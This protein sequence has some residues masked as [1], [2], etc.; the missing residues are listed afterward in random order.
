MTSVRG[1]PTDETQSSIPEEA[2]SVS[3]IN[4]EIETVLTEAAEQFPSYIVGEIADVSH[5]D[6]GT[7][8]DL[9]DID[10]E[11][12]ISCFAWS[13]AVNSF[14]YDLEAG[15]TA[16]VQASVD[17]YQKQGDTRLVV[18]EYWPVGESQRV[19]ELEALRE[20]LAEEGAFDEQ[21][22]QPLPAYPHEVGVVTSPSGSALEDF[23]STVTARWPIVSICLCGASVQGETAIADLVEAIQELEHDPTVEVIVVT[24]GGG[25][26]A[27]L[28]VF[29]R[30]PVVRAIVEC[31]TPVVVAVGHEDDETLAERVADERAMTPTA[32]GVAVTPE[33]EA[34]ANRF[35][36]L[37]RRIADGYTGLVE[38]RL[39]AVAGRITAGVSTIEQE[40]VTREATQQ[41]VADL[42]RRLTTAYTSLAKTRLTEI[43]RRID[44][45]MQ[46]IEQTA[47]TEQASATAARGRM[48]DLEARIDQT[49][50]QTVDRQLQTI[51]QRI[52]TAYRELEAETKVQA[53]KAEAK[54]LR[55][56]IAVLLILLL[57]VAGFVIL[58]L[59]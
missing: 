2:W 6:F 5:Y 11:A 40:A 39:T 33:L 14:E 57:L 9:A 37:E 25:A 47:V 23:N 24:R 46:S 18:R 28:W 36:T 30:E 1:G 8:F 43:D 52:D 34:I 35:E 45:A 38:E 48:V 51:E 50:R 22:R 55:L 32:A 53:G 17:H 49:Y 29:N 41:R 56:V 59:L 54:K 21:A 27:T 3:R 42:K 19:E 10:A 13:N 58:L 20:T 44:Q 12:R 4:D 16:V 7:F 15:V 26:D 31:T